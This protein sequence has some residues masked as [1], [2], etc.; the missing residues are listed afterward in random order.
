MTADENP[1]KDEDFD[2]DSVAARTGQDI[3]LYHKVIGALHMNCLINSEKITVRVKNRRVHL[4]GTVGSENERNLAAK[5]IA[6][7]FGI[8]AIYNSIT[9]PFDPGH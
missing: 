7:I 4:E 6:E 9:F 2:F 5:C 3:D 1:E 8:R